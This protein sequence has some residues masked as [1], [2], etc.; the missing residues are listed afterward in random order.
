MPG[1]LRK[2]IIIF[3]AV[4]FLMAEIYLVKLPNGTLKP[5]TEDDEEALKRFK[6]G[7]V[8]KAEV[9]KPRNYQNHKRFFALLQVVASY[10][11]IYNN[12]EKAKLAV[13]VASGHCDFIE[14]P[15]IPGELIAQPRSISYSR[16]DE[17]QFAKFFNDAVQGV[18]SH[19]LPDLDEDSLNA[20]VEEVIRF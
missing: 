18:I 10:H 16:M 6:V 1:R 15:L 7:E 14:N 13:T 19:I 9:K 3:L 12:V 11:E 17:I 20:A 2:A 4:L 8:V 5:D